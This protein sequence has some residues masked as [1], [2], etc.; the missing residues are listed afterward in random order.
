MEPILAP[1]VKYNLAVAEEGMNVSY[2]AQVGRT[3][4]ETNEHT[5]K[6][7]ARAMAAAGSD[8]RM[9]GCSLPVI[10][11]SGSGNQG[12]TL[13]VPLVV[14]ARECGYSEE[15]LYRALAISNLV[16]IHI[17]KYIGTLS[18]FCGA[19]SAGAAAGAGITYMEGGNYEQISTTIINVLGNLGGVIC[20]GAKA[21]CAA[22]ISSAIDAAFMSS[23]M[24][25]EGR[26]FL[27][28]QGIVIDDIEKTIKNVGHVAKE[29]M[30]TTDMEILKL[31]LEDEN[32]EMCC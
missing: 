24:A 13:A 1:Q 10:V 30:Y 23:E 8:A 3:V 19:I 12:L 2:G 27:F 20:D 5:A 21:S 28:G 9:G 16:A 18:A 17:K 14:Y 32:R 15:K 4:L 7:K 29:G 6:I 22:K 31:M 26:T 11:N 25:M